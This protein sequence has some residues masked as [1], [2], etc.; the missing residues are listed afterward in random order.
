MTR[1]LQ[2]TL[3]QEESPR[4]PPFI[5]KY[6]SR[7]DWVRR[8][9]HGLCT[10]CCTLLKCTRATCRL[11]KLLVL[12]CWCSQSAAAKPME[13]AAPP[14]W[15]FQLELLPWCWESPREGREQQR[16]KSQ[17]WHWELSL[18]A[19]RDSNQMAKTVFIPQTIS[20]IPCRQLPFH[21]SRDNDTAQAAASAALS[22][23]AWSIL[24]Q[25]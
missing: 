6:C 11:G 10:E 21:H 22:S 20:P 19:L 17:G 9:K 16:A 18:H 23:P 2:I 5:W 1:L 3:Y 8:Y 25:I 12:F 7:H 4:N 13:G 14:A 24:S 15:R